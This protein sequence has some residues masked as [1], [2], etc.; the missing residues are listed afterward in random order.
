MT[1]EHAKRDEMQHRAGPLLNR[2]SLSTERLV[3]SVCFVVGGWALLESRFV[4]WGS[5]CLVAALL[6]PV[7]HFVLTQY[8]AS[9]PSR[10]CAAQ[11]RDTER[12]LEI[13]RSEAPKHSGS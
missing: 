11:K 2:R 6:V 4:I 5:V 7:L 10:M 3:M 1:E 12:L 9:L 13:A 8:Q